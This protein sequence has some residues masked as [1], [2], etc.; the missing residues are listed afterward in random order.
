M[1]KIIGIALVLILVSIIT[2]LFKNKVIPKYTIVCSSTCSLQGTFSNKVLEKKEAD[3][4]V[5]EIVSSLLKEKKENFFEDITVIPGDVSTL[6]AAKSAGNLFIIYNPD[7]VNSLRKGV[8]GDMMLKGVFAHMIAHH[9]LSHKESQEDYNYNNEYHA[10]KYAGSIM[11]SFVKDSEQ[12]TNLFN[13][14]VYEFVSN[15]QVNL[16]RRITAMLDGWKSESKPPKEP[17]TTTWIPNEDSKIRQA[18]IGKIYQDDYYH[19]GVHIKNIKG[20]FYEDGSFFKE[21]TIEA[22][23]FG[24]GDDPVFVNIR[25][26]GTYII[27]NKYLYYDYNENSFSFN[28]TE[29]MERF[30]ITEEKKYELI[31]QMKSRNSPEEVIEYDPAKVVTKDVDGKRRVYKKSY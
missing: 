11:Y 16:N 10:D 7:Y 8:N 1:R 28:P 14:I 3:Y 9:M 12:A 13:S 15:N 27:R 26:L 29:V 30:F 20:E 21:L 19:D 24:E 31:E 5:N 6:T 23:L 18:L 25:F 17:D 4:Y 2:V 22:E